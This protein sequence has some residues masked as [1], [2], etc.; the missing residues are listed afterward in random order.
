MDSEKLSDPILMSAMNPALMGQSALPP[1]DPTANTGRQDAVGAPET[2]NGDTSGMSN[3]TKRGLKTEM[4]QEAISASAPLVRKKFTFKEAYKEL[5]TLKRVGF[6]LHE[7]DKAIPKGWGKIAS[8]M[9][10]EHPVIENQLSLIKW[11][12]VQGYTPDGE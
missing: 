9:K 12:D 7:S 2:Y 3:D 6:K 11:M 10:K 4:A 1:D 5:E 8:K